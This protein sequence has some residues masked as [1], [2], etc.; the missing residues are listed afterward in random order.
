MKGEIAL[1][2]FSLETG[3]Q[4]GSDVTGKAKK[5]KLISAAIV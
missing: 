1:V 2:I 5:A 4:R 3:S